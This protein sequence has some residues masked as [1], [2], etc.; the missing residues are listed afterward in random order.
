MQKLD[1]LV[2]LAVTLLLTVSAC[3]GGGILG[4]TAT[5]KPTPTPECTAEDVQ[6]F[7]D[8]LEPLLGRWDDRAEVAGSTARM[9]LSPVITGMQDIKRDVEEL[10]APWCAEETQEKAVAYMDQYIDG[11]LRS[12]PTSLMPQ[13]KKNLSALV[14]YLTSSSWRELH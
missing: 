13:S 3:G 6:A 4:P 11:Y 2:V 1:L 5:P 7:L 12:W 10:E 9:N 8:E 14:S